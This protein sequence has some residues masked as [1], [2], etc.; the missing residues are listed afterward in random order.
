VDEEFIDPIYLAVM[1]NPVVI[2]SGVTMDKSSF[3]NQ[4]G[5]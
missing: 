1:V 3:Y 4:D 2:S 5:T